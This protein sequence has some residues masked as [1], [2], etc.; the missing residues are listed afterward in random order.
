MVAFDPVGLTEAHPKLTLHMKRLRAALVGKN[1]FFNGQRNRARVFR[2]IDERVPFENYVETGTFLGMT[3]D[4][5]ARRARA[6]GA[7]VHSCE[8]NDRHYAIAQR[9]VGH[10]PHVRLQ[11]GNSIEF[12]RELAPRISK[13]TNFVYLDA[14]WR[15]YLPLR[16]ELSIIR[17]WPNT[18]VLIDDFKVPSDP[19][20]GWDRYDEK[21][22]I[23]LEHIA[24][25]FGDNPIFFP[26]Y[27]APDERAAPRGYCVMAM[28][29]PLQRVLAEIPLLKRHS[30]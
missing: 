5:L 19:R 12:L 11:L 9:I 25:T 14:H 16:D 4:F 28:S 13:A 8:I 7:Q 10:Q 2:A 27:P 23:C 6:K 29:T 22:E 24:G 18:I 3:T 1:Y 17:K 15:D 21:Q 30:D 20:F 26:N